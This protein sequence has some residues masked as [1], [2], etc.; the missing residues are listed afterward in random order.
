MSLIRIER[1]PS[2]RQLATFG[3]VWF[4]AF[5]IFGGIALSRSGLPWATAL[6]AAAVLVPGIGCLAPALL[7]AVYVGMACLTYPIGVVVSLVLLAAV[8][9]LVLTPI[10]LLLRLFGYDPMCRRR[11][12]N[13]VSY[14]TPREPADD[15]R[16]YFR[17]F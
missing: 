5:A 11:D 10:G 13:A 16:R 12:P 17:Q 3:V 15:V 4:V 9:Y 2:R 6:W 7:R 1:N 14:W 8:Y